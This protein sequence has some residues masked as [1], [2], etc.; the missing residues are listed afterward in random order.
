MLDGQLAALA[1]GTFPPAQPP[2]AVAHLGLSRADPRGNCDEEDSIPDD[3]AAVRAVAVA[4]RHGREGRL[5]C[6]G[7]RRRLLHDLVRSLLHMD[8]KGGLERSISGDQEEAMEGRTAPRKGGGE[9]RAPAR[10]RTHGT[11]MQRT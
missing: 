9:A 2:R 10:R 1:A 6:R 7:G 11:A 5:W 4:R 8:S 3:F